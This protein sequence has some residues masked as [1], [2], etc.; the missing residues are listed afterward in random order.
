MPERRRAAMVRIIG[1]II[2]IMITIISIAM[3]MVVD[4]RTL[5]C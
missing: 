5:A 3:P 1:I 4:V 2:I